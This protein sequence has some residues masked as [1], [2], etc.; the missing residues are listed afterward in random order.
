VTKH[1]AAVYLRQSEARAVTCGE[2][3]YRIAAGVWQVLT[4]HGSTWH[5]T[6]AAPHDGVYRRVDDLEE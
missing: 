1:E 5:T 3:V 6:D 4:G 2:R